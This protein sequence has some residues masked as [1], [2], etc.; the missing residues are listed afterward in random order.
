[1]TYAR[2]L[3]QQQGQPQRQQLH[4]SRQWGTKGPR[5]TGSASSGR[6]VGFCGYRIL[7]G[8]GAGTTYWSPG[9]SGSRF[10]RSLDD[11]HR[12]HFGPHA[13]TPHWPSRLRK[14]TAAPVESHLPGVGPFP[15][16]PVETCV[17]SLGA[18]VVS[19]PGASEGVCVGAAATTS[20]VP[21]FVASSGTTSQPAQLSFTLDFGASSC[22]FR[23]CTNLTPL[24]TPA[25][26]ALA[27][28]S[29]GPVVAH[30]TTTLPCP[31]APFGFLIGYYTPSFSRNLVGVSHLHDLGVVIT[32]SLDEPIASRTVRATGALLA[33]FYRESGFGLYSQQTGSHHTGLGS[34]RSTRVACPA[35]SL[36]CAAVHSLRQGSAVRCPSPLLVP[37]HHG[38]FP[39]PAL[40]CLSPSPVLGPHQERYFL[41]VVDDYSRYTTVFPLR[42]KADRQVP[43]VSGGAGGAVAEGE[44]AG[45]AGAG[46]VGSGGAR[47]VGVEVIPVEDTAASTQWPRPTPPPGFLYVPQFPPRSSLQ[48]LATEPG[49]VPARGTGGTRGAGGGG[50]DYGGA[51]A[52]GTG[53]VA[54]T[55]CTVRFLTCAQRLLRLDREEHERWRDRGGVTAATGEGRAGVSPAVA[56][57]VANTAGESRA[58]VTA[59]AGEGRGGA[60]GAAT[61][62][63]AAATDARGGRAATTLTLAR[64][65]T[66]TLGSCCAVSPEPH[67]SR[68]RVD[69]PFHLV[70]HSHVPP[71]PVLAQP[72]SLTVFH[73]PLSDF[74]RAV[75]GP[76]GYKLVIL[77]GYG[78]SDPLLNKPF[79]PN[80]LVVGILTR[81]SH[82]VVSHVLSSQVT[83]PTAPSLSVSALVTT[84]A[85]FASSHRLDYATHPVSGPARSLSSGGAPIFPLEVLEDRP[86]ELGFLAAAVTH[87]CAM[88]LALERDPDALEIPIPRTHAEAVSGP[89]ASY[90]IATEE[91]EMASYRSIGTYVNAVPPPRANVTFAPTPKMTTLWVLLHIAAQR[92]YELHSLDFSTAFLQGSLH[93]QIWLRCPPGFTGSFQWQLRQPVYGLRLAPRKWHDILRTTLAALDF[94]PSSADPSMFIHR[95]LTPFFVVVYVVD[96]VFATPDRCALASVKE[97]LQRRHTCTDLGELQ[98]YLGLQIIKDR[99]ARTITLTQS[100]MVEQILV[101]YLGLQIIR[102]RAARTIT[103]MQSHMV[104]QILTQFCFPFS[105]VQP[106]LVAVDHG[107]TAPPSD[108]PFESSGPYPELVGCLISNCEVEVY[109]AAMAAPELRWLS[110]LFTDLSEQPRSPPVVFVDNSSMARHLCDVWSLRPKLQISSP[111]RCRLAHCV[112]IFFECMKLL[113]KDNGVDDCVEKRVGNVNLSQGVLF[114]GGDADEYAHRVV[115]IFQQD[116]QI[117]RL[118]FDHHGEFSSSLLDESCHEEGITH[119]FTLPA[120]PQQ[121][122]IAEHRIGLIMEA[123]RTSMIHAAAPHFL[124]PFVVRYAA[125]QLNL[126][127]RSSLPEPSSTLLWTGS[128]GDASVF[129]VWGSLALVRNPTAD[130]LSLRTIHCVFLGF[131]TNALD[132]QYYHPATRRVLCSRDVTFDKSVCYYHLFPHQSCPVSPDSFGLA[133]GGDPAADKT[134]ASRRPPRLETPPS[135]PPRSSLLP[136]QPVAVDSGGP[137]VVRSGDYGGAGIGGAGSGGGAFKGAGSSCAGSRGADAEG[138]APRGAAG[139]RFGGV[140]GTTAGGS[141]GALYPLPRRPVF[142]EQQQSSLPLR[143]SA[144]GG[145]GGAVSRVP[146]P[147]GIGY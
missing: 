27:D 63:G 101:R 128:V 36:T 90:W 106:T 113:D 4:H 143:G 60:T 16:V 11:L 54:P 2:V 144:A 19:S 129:W 6:D 5:I 9:H 61:G 120:S 22:F 14:R 142:W 26:V 23:D 64:P 15:S 3:Q 130:K 135:F 141:E 109:A 112:V 25:T 70:L 74:L 114:D 92:E 89:W 81:A 104:E 68:Y 66:C 75:R 95:G 77:G 38:S 110:F 39:D 107:L 111:R 44:G 30:I 80:G 18:C 13:I 134:A 97:E 83:H 43:V 99:A 118:H 93:E 53:T 137:D 115:R 73:D 42:Q 32:F 28:P 45:A 98:H 21:T 127:P 40:G 49:V 100:H 82:P 88:L 55:P 140:N 94:I 76:L 58:G 72:P 69:G 87:L 65:C 86:F 57:A 103:L 24:Y 7:T 71:P 17:S 78:R 136:L 102:D 84:I 96:L 35:S 33:T 119:L 85:G 132:W 1:M 37:P 59:A 139:P 147:G 50:A 122:G 67:R 10:Y 48:P 41:I 108:E 12:E 47:G 56:G 8:P 79:C 20:L 34:V 145:S 91:A 46:G 131:P 62:A 123:A 121:N 138:A 116:L 126:W 51:G 29:M 133:E 31:A 52:G 125:H 146:A 117:L 105:K 124:W